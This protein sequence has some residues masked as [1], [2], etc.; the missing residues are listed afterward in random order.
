VTG[1]KPFSRGALYLLLRN[2]IYRG[3]TVHKGQSHPGEHK[4]IIDQPL[5]DAVQAQ[6]VSNAAERSSGARTRQPSLLAGI[7]FD[8][9]GNRMTPSHAAKKGVTIKWRGQGQ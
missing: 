6:L 1:G 2:R 5:W 4:P 3:E 7:L 9:D 8:R